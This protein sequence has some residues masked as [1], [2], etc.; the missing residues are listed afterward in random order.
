MASIRGDVKGETSLPLA[1][2]VDRMI[3]DTQQRGFHLALPSFQNI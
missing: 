1:S 2:G 3:D